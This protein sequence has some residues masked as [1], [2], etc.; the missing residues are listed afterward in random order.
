MPALAI[1]YAY[2]AHTTRGTHNTQRAYA[3]TF[4]YR[5]F[6]YRDTALS[7]WLYLIYLTNVCEHIPVLL[8]NLFMSQ[9][10]AHTARSASHKPKLRQALSWCRCF[11][12]LRTLISK[13]TGCVCLWVKIVQA[14]SVSFPSRSAMKSLSTVAHS[15]ILGV[16]QINQLFS[17]HFD[18][19]APIEH[20]VF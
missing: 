8:S 12:T 7:H 11:S 3:W 15:C 2:V 14:C 17:L 6:L 9:T 16:K 10:C 13:S 20:C 18:Y 5:L 19:Y 4:S 1:D